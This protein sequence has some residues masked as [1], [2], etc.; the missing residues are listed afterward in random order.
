ME[1]IYHVAISITEKV[2]ETKIIIEDKDSHFI[3]IKGKFN[4]IT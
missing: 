4:K 3:M 2:F 1:N